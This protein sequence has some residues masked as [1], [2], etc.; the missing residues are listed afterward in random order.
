MA[1]LA[2]NQKKDGHLSDIKNMFPSV[3]RPLI[4]LD[5]EDKWRRGDARLEKLLRQKLKK[6]LG[7]PQ[8]GA[9]V[10]TI[11]KSNEEG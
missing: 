4:D 1:W 3:K 2:R 7:E 8:S 9:G 10:G 6:H 5:I 11:E